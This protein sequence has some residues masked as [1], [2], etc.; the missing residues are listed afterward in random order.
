VTVE[1]CDSQTDA[2]IRLD[3]SELETLTKL[4]TLMRLESTYPCMPTM[5]ITDSKGQRQD[6]V[7]VRQDD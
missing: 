6:F 7:E 2:Q 5:K 3:T 1:G 4:A